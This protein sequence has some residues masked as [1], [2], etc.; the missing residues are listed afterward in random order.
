[1][2]TCTEAATVAPQFVPSK[3]FRRGIIHRQDISSK[4]M[5]EKQKNTRV[6][7]LLRLSSH[8]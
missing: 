8:V 5:K 2:E 3:L 1:M 4:Q 7:Q 6:L